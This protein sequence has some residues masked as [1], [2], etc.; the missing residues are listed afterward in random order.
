M[1]VAGFGF[2]KEA[3]EASLED[4]YA[5][6]CKSVEPV[7]LATADDKAVAKVFRL[8]AEAMELP[9]KAVPP[10]VLREQTTTTQSAASRKSHGTGSVAEAAALAAAGKG[11]RLLTVRQT[12]ADKLATCALA[13]KEET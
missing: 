4:A 3:S 13:I 8:F 12:S 10:D 1:I 5:R 9:V 11:A 2:R 6:A 7:L